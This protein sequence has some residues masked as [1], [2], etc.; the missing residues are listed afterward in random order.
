MLTKTVDANDVVALVREAR[1]YR[2]ERLLP[3]EA[4]ATDK[5]EVAL[6]VGADPVGYTEVTAFEQGVAAV[7]G[8]PEA[9][10]V[11]SG[12]A[13]LH[14]ALKAIDIKRGDEVIVPA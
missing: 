2:P 7:V 14:L 13:A 4:T 1:P 5:E 8:M 12:T 9:L 3:F 11:S 6:C 10:A